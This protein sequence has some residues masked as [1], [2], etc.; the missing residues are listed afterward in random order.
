MLIQHAPGA[1]AVQSISGF[2]DEPFRTS[3]GNNNKKHTNENEGRASS[4]F[5]SSP[6]LFVLHVFRYV[7]FDAASDKRAPRAVN[8][9]R[10][11]A[12]KRE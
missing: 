3:V 2:V 9:S 10:Q 6:L 11:L 5:S 1:N 8:I 12:L 7:L 4:F